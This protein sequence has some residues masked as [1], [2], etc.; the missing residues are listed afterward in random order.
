M[1][2]RRFSRGTIFINLFRATSDDVARRRQGAYGQMDEL[3]DGLGEAVV[4]HASPVKRS[5][6]VG[7][8]GVSDEP[9]AITGF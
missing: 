3:V 8:D 9:V 5:K 2:F 4:Y 1:N 7:P 6:V